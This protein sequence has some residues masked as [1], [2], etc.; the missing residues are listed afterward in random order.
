VA[1]GGIPD[2][3]ELVERFSGKTAVTRDGKLALPELPQ[4]ATL[5]VAE[6]RATERIQT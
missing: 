4:G 6:A 5:W 2:G 3:L 1:H